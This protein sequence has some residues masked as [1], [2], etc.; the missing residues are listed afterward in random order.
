MQPLPSL[1]AFS[2]PPP[3][4][5]RCHS[6]ERRTRR[7]TVTSVANFQRSAAAERASCSGFV[8]SLVCTCRGETSVRGRGSPH[9][10][11]SLPA[12]KYPECWEGSGLQPVPVSDPR[13]ERHA[14]HGAAN[15]QPETDKSRGGNRNCLGGR[16]AFAWDFRTAGANWVQCYCSPPPPPPLPHR[17]R[18]STS[19]HRPRPSFSAP[20][21]QFPPAPSLQ[22]AR[23]SLAS[24]PLSCS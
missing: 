11:N 1:H 7:R 22:V 12:A 21:K 23:V 6:Q 19:T 4:P 9:P 17:P 10:R 16:L 5:P 13:P 8:C 24:R 20:A 14:Q 18:L 3:P 2:S 15:R